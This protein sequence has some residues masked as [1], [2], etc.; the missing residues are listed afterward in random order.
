MATG[1]YY[2]TKKK[3][4][5]KTKTKTRKLFRGFEFFVWGQKVWRP[6]LVSHQAHVPCRG[7][8]NARG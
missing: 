8:W 7:G 3:K 6:R 4:K 1:K 2:L 5:T